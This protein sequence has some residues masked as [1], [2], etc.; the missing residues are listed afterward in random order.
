[1]FKCKFFL[2][3]G[4][5]FQEFSRRWRGYVEN[6]SWILDSD[7]YWNSPQPFWEGMPTRI[8]SQIASSVVTIIKGDANYRRIHGDLRWKY[9]A[10][11]AEIVKYFPGSRLLLRTLKAE[12]QTGLTAETLDW[13]QKE[14][15][16]LSSGKFGLV[17]FITK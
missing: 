6:G 3:F 11:T 10:N 15:N 4:N 5:K 1:M 2:Y 13:V 9:T 8:Q 17:Q 14:E 12:I 7:F 16:W